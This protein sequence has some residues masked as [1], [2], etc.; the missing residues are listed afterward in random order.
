MSLNIPSLS[1]KA[2]TNQSSGLITAFTKHFPSTKSLNSH[3]R[4][5]VSSGS[6]QP[7]NITCLHTLDCEQPTICERSSFPL[8][9]FHESKIYLL[10]YDIEQD[11]LVNELMIYP[12]SGTV[13]AL[14]SLNNWS[15]IHMDIEVL[16]LGLS[17]RQLYTVEFFLKTLLEGFNQLLISSCTEQ[18]LKKWKRNVFFGIMF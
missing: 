5:S 16:K 2:L 14:S 7:L 9:L 3:R 12:S 11:K 6:F 4:Y 15:N 10:L 13:E 1:S 18:W 17:N 8:L